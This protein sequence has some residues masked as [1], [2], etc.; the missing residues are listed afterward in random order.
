MRR[1]RVPLAALIVTLS[2]A[3][4]T[5][6]ECNS[7]NVVAPPLPPLSKVVLTPPSDTLVV[8]ATKLFTATAY[9]TNN[10]AV[11]GAAFD[12][13]SGDPNVFT[14]S[15]TGLVTAVGEGVSTLIAAAGGKSD[16]SIVAV[17]VQPGWYAQT[18]GTSTTLNGV[19]FHGD[20]RR[21]VA[22]GNVGAIVRT[23]D[24]GASWQIQTS[25][26]TVDLNDVWFTTDSTGFAVGNGGTVMRTRNGGVSWARLN[27]TATTDN[28]LGACFAD[29]SHGWVVGAN[30]TILR[31]ANG[32]ASW[33]KLNP[34]AQQLNSVSFSDTTDGWAVGEGGVIVGTHDGGRSW[35]IVQPAVTALGLHTV[36]RLSNTRAIAGGVAGVNPFTT[37]TPD[38]LQWTLGSFGAANQVEG[39]HMVD[40]ATGFA[41]GSNGSGL[42]L[43]TVNGGVTWAPQV[44][45]SVQGLRDV[46]FVDALRGWA[47]GAGGR[48]LHTSKGGF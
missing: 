13:T 1:S 35:Y 3:S 38:S 4:F 23:S 45:N 39:L 48:I 18:S 5:G 29:T 19:F 42:V 41:V 27:N 34:T 28:L 40:D 6:C 8:G 7:V 47:V 30:G 37:A 16:T 9:D 32:G 12:W 33:T 46:W 26:T 10:V 24:A 14:V 2:V 36:W 21:G 11:P 15:R 20:G 44:A 25:S 43:R 31:T 17:V 22:V